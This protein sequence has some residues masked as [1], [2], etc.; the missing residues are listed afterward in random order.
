VTVKIDEKYHQGVAEMLDALPERVVR[1]RLP[2][3]AISYCNRAWAAGH[4]CTPAE[5]IGRTLNEFLTASERAGV[6]SQLARLGPDNRLVADDV[7]RAA[8]NAPGQWVEW[9]DQYLPGSDG[10]EVLAVGRDVTGRHI[11]ELN[12]ADSE[13]RFRELADASAD[14]VWR[15]LL[16]PH[17]HFDYLSPSV[18][19]LLG[20]PPS[21]FLEDFSR[22]L[23]MLDDESK[24]LI[25]RGLEG[26]PMP[27]RFDTQFRRD[28]GSIT[29]GE[30]Q[31]SSVPGG[32]QG[33]TRDVTEL[34][35]LQQELADLALRD[36]L[37][38]LANRRLFDE[39]LEAGLSRTKRSGRPLAVA[40]LDLDNFKSVND[41]Y[42]HDAGDIVLCEIA[43]RLTAVVRDAEVVARLG[44]D[45]FVIVYEPRDPS[46]SNLLARIDRALAPPIAVSAT[47][48]LSCPASIG[49]ADT[50]SVGHDAAALLA[51]ADADMYDVKRSR[52]RSTNIVSHAVVAI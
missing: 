45:E 38:G 31:T 42:G 15:F 14:V 35:R 33:V 16:H 52:G 36:P 24:K 3:L 29:I 17:P 13:A 20:H 12:L 28:D 8:P 18:E 22:F 19:T 2:E 23:E 49:R 10:D 1:F 5:V 27:E 7:P 32:M 50:R 37:T 21:V 51:A 25:G 30:A 39:L 4:N 47:V 44:G 6:K 26:A 40:Y 46:S 41:M 34:R 11:A 48:K 43:R 9:V